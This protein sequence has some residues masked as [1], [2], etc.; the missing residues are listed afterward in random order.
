MP[1]IICYYH[2]IAIFLIFVF[3]CIRRTFF[4]SI[5]ITLA[6]F[7]LFFPPIFVRTTNI[8]SLFLTRANFTLNAFQV[9]MVVDGPL[10][11]YLFV[12]R[13][14][15][16]LGQAEIDG[17]ER[18]T[19]FLARSII[20]KLPLLHFWKQPVTKRLLPPLPFETFFVNLFTPHSPSLRCCETTKKK[21]LEA[22]LSSLNWQPLK[23]SPSSLILHTTEITRSA[24]DDGAA[25]FC[26]APGSRKTE[27]SDN[28]SKREKRGKKTKD[29]Y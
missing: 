3:F 24:P 20:N 7:S 1:V 29:S 12:S 19:R 17:L 25:S 5:F 21:R 9:L 13:L 8:P 27:S 2:K 18:R 4:F 6:S 23:F 28:S 15:L 14:K 26:R 10:V 22:L 11:S 16:D